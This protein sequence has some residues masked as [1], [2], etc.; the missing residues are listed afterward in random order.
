V[1]DGDLDEIIEALSVAHREELLSKGIDFDE[2][3]T[4]N[5]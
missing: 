5:E 3:A 4:G 2:T 1:L